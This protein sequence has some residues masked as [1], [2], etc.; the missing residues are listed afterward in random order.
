MSVTVHTTVGDFKMELFCEQCPKVGTCTT[1]WNG[2]TNMTDGI[3][4]KPG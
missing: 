2:H 3:L 4:A 1:H